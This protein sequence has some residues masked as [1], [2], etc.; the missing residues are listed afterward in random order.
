[1]WKYAFRH[2]L[3]SVI[4]VLLA[5]VY[6]IFF[7][8]PEDVTDFG[9]IV[10]HIMAFMAVGLLLE[11][12]GTRLWRTLHPPE[13]T[14]YYGGHEKIIDVAPMEI[15]LPD[16]VLLKDGIHHTS[17][18]LLP[19]GGGPRRVSPFPSTNFLMTPLEHQEN[20]RRQL[21]KL[22]FTLVV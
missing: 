5:A 2:F 17:Y 11:W 14:T 22:C 3:L 1:M 7:A 10:A 8:R 16:K 20:V 18:M 12:V 13:R 9:V 6:L 19:S 15:L 4:Y 21:K